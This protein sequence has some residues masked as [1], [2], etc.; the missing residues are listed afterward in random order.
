MP[1]ATIDP[2]RGQSASGG[3][4]AVTKANSSWSGVRGYSLGSHEVP[5]SIPRDQRYYWT[6]RWQ[7]EEAETLAAY[8]RG[9]GREFE[10]GLDAVRWLLDNDD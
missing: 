2:E 10:T 3:P 1:T 9:E 5:P 7:R 8:E 4:A 6:S